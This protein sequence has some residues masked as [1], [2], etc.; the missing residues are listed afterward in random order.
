M[1]NLKIGLL[2][3]FKTKALSVALVAVA[4]CEL[5]CATYYQ[6]FDADLD[7]SIGK[8][9]MDLRYPPLTNVLAS[10]YE[11]GKLVKTYSLNVLALCRW[12]FIF[13]SDTGRIVSWRYPDKD[14]EKRCHQLPRSM[15]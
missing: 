10:R 15:T 9:S 13:E 4:F 6:D 3:Q 12:E 11:G 5:G 8:T 7:A 2:A 14:A 1:G